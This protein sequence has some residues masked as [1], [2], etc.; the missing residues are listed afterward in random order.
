MWGAQD[1]K[2]TPSRM[3]SAVFE[4]KGFISH[5]LTIVVI[6]PAAKQ[7]MA[8][9]G[10]TGDPASLERFYFPTSAQ[11]A[12]SPRPSEAISS[13]RPSTRSVRSNASTRPSTRSFYSVASAESRDHVHGRVVQVKF[14]PIEDSTNG[15]PRFPGATEAMNAIAVLVLDASEGHA[16]DGQVRMLTECMFHHKFTD[17]MKRAQTVRLMMIGYQGEEAPQAVVDLCEKFELALLQQDDW[18]DAR[19]AV[20]ALAHDLVDSSRAVS[21]PQE[22]QDAQGWRRWLRRHGELFDRLRKSTRSS[23]KESG[24]TRSDA[25][26]G[27]EGAE[28]APPPCRRRW[29]LSLC[30]CGSKGGAPYLSDQAESGSQARS[31]AAQTASEKERDFAGVFGESR[32]DRDAIPVTLVD[33]ACGGPAAHETL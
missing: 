19:D 7:M 14:T 16:V 15:V 9:F 13:A 6:G 4:S 27:P 24:S 29:L 31:P 23:P 28:K 3:L 12:N 21:V 5:R 18:E 33:E 8:C 11:R 20:E 22:S 30:A 26:G 25:R 17:P 32:G 10:L 2:N 1:Q